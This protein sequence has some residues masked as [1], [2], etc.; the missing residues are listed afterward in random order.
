MTPLDPS[1]RVFLDLTLDAKRAVDRVCTEFERAARPARIEDYLPRVG[2]ALRDAL[3]TELVILEVELRQGAGESPAADEYLARFPDRAAAVRTAFRQ[4]SGPAVGEALGKYRL[5]GVLG[6]G[7]MGVVYEAVDPVIDRTVAVK[8]LPD[9]LLADPLARDR[10]LQEA[11]LAGQLQH[12]NVVTLYEVG[13]ADGVTFLVLERVP[14]G[15]AADRIAAGPLDWRAATLIIADVCRGL[16]AIHA[17][18]FLHLDIKPAN[19]LLPSRAP[20]D[21]GSKPTGGAVLAKLT[22]FSLAITGDDD[23]AAGVVAGTPA[24]MSPEQR[25][26]GAVSRR[27]DVYGLGA[28]YFALLAGRAP[29]AGPTRTRVG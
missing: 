26:S 21:G 4:S 12:P 24:Y 5:T 7:G 29:F 8:V 1:T 22:D 17:A 13:E 3:L 14:G 23:G 20:V 2:P 28:A 10:L 15:S 18:G 9:R 11:R 27:T 25:T 6:R 16:A 19:V